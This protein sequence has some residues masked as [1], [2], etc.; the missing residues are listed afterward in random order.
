[1]LVSVFASGVVTVASETVGMD[2]RRYTSAG[3]VCVIV[4]RPALETDADS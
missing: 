4:I 3:W 2:N 1:M